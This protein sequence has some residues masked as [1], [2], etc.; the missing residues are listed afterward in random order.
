MFLSFA[1]IGCSFPG[2]VVA[3][4]EI[5][6]TANQVYEWNFGNTEL[7]Q[8]NIEVSLNNLRVILLSSIICKFKPALN[9]NH[10]HVQICFTAICH[11]HCQLKVKLTSWTR[12]S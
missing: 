8:K 3:A 12:S 4:M 9:L 11:V 6:T 5:N 10:I 1:L 2:K 7:F